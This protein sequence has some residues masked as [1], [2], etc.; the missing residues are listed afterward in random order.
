KAGGYQVKFGVLTPGTYCVTLSRN[1]TVDNY[2]PLS[3]MDG[4]W[5]DPRT[6]QILAQETIDFGPGNHDYV[7]RFVWDEIDR[8][9][10]TYP[11]VDF[12][13]KCKIGPEKVCPTVGFA[14]AGETIPILGRDRRSEWMLTQLN[15]T[16]CYVQIPGFLIDKY[17]T[18]FGPG[19]SRVADLEIFPQPDP[20]PKPTPE[21]ACSSYSSQSSCAAAGCTWHSSRSADYCSDN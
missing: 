6:N 10:L 13:F 20:C 3:L 21:P 14:Q 7:A 17:L 1:Q 8:T 12:T 18:E 11:L 19:G 4:I 9:F 5:T 2:G 16:P 15:G